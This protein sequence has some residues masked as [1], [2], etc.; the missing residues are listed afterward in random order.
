MTNTPRTVNPLFA[1]NLR[2][3]LTDRSMTQT[4]LA[5]QLGVSLRAVQK[6]VAGDA[7]PSS[8]TF[9]ALAELLDREPQWFYTEPEREAA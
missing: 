4:M 1:T 3:A 6:W 5:L 7:I 2:L 8:Q 9:L